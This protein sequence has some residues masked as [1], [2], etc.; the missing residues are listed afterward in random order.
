MADKN[1][2][3]F[4]EL[5]RS[6]VFKVE[7][8]EV[9]VDKDEWITYALFQDFLNDTETNALQ[10]LKNKIMHTCGINQLLK[11]AEVILQVII[12]FYMH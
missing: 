4:T 11:L 10:Q 3:L 5:I 12:F 9:Y 6:V 8:R 7:I 1:K 2:A